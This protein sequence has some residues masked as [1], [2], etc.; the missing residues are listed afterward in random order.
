MKINYIG[1]IGAI[2]AFISIV[3]PWWTLTT[4]IEIT[5]SA[6]LYLYQPSGTFGAVVLTTDEAWFCWAALALIIVAGVLGIVG[7]ATGYGK[8]I[9]IGGG[10]FALLSIIIFAVGLQM[11][12]LGANYGLFATG[13][14]YSAYLS[15]GFWLALVAMILM[16]AAIVLKPKE[17]ATQ[18]Q[19]T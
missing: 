18:S 10:A 16:F 2:L 14:D 6:D 19:P 5:T 8:K 11:S 1:L 15:Y 9:L 7:S 17:T 13:L 12:S 4:T 3:L